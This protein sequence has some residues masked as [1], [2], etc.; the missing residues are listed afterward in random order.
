MNIPVGH[1]YVEFTDAESA[2]KAKK[3]MG[4]GKQELPVI[5]SPPF[6][7]CCGIPYLACYPA[8]LSSLLTQLELCSLSLYV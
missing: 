4:G 3:Y 1:A 2:A 6:I 5:R 8:L 7:A